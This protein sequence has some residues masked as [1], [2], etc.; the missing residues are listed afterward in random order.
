MRVIIGIRA[1][2]E[3]EGAGFGEGVVAVEHDGVEVEGAAVG[4]DGVLYVVVAEG[5][6]ELA[7]PAAAAVGRRSTAAVGVGVGGGE[8]EWVVDEV[9]ADEGVVDV[10]VGTL[11]FVD[12]AEEVACG[13]QVVSVVFCFFC[14]SGWWKWLS[15]TPF[16]SHLWNAAPS[17]S[18][19]G[20][21]Q[22]ART[23]ANLRGSAIADV[24]IMSHDGD[25]SIRSS[26]LI[27]QLDKANTWD[28]IGPGGDSSID[29]LGELAFRVIV[30]VAIVD[31]ASGP[32]AG[33]SGPNRVRA[34]DCTVDRPRIAPAR[35]NCTVCTVGPRGVC[36]VD[37]SFIELCY[38][39]EDDIAIISH[40]ACLRIK[41]TDLLC[42]VRELHKASG[43]IRRGSLDLSSGADNEKKCYE[44]HYV[45]GFESNHDGQRIE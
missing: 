20:H 8:S 1:A 27:G 37:N 32:Y 2:G 39:A 12:E 13:F 15:L 30:P 22:S 10:G 21:P 5:G 26:L 9:G 38:G 45:D 34:L 41:P 24:R 29:I 11:L 7:G 40:E 18:I 6:G 33:G 43:Q 36:D 35:D 14:R 3:R 44:K 16:M 42:A 19:E 23:V 17:T 31:F 28:R 25:N 4:A